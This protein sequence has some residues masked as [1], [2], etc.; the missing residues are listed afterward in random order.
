MLIALVALFFFPC[1]LWSVFRLLVRVLVVA[2]NVFNTS[3]FHLIVYR[4]EDEGSPI[5]LQDKQDAQQAAT[6]HLVQACWGV[7]A[8]LNN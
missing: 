1:Y 3:F 2:P 8:V 6:N 5:K 4:D 7:P